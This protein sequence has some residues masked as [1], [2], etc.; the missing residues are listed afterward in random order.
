MTDIIDRA[1]F[2]EEQHRELALKKHQEQQQ[3][4]PGDGYCLDCNLPILPARLKALPNVS[5]CVDCQ[6]L[7]EIRGGQVARG[8]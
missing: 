1:S 8:H 2:L 3:Q 5:R 7:Q 4:K 6:H